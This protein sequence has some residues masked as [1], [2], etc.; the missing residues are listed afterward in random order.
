MTNDC[1][2][3]SNSVEMYCPFDSNVIE[4]RLREPV[5][6]PSGETSASSFRWRKMGTNTTLQNLIKSYSRVYSLAVRN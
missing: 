5:Y 1:N 4:A 3:C 2:S 6:P